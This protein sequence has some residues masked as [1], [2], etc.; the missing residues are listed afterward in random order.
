MVGNKHSPCRVIKRCDE[1]QHGSHNH[2]RSMSGANVDD[3][4]SSGHY[5]TFFTHNP[6]E[7]LTLLDYEQ[8]VNGLFADGHFADRRLVDRHKWDG[9]INNKLYA[10]KPKL[11]E[12]ALAC[13]KSRKEEINKKPCMMKKC[14][15]YLQT[16]LILNYCFLSSKVIIDKW[17]TKIKNKTN[18]PQH[19]SPSDI[20]REFAHR[21]PRKA[22]SNGRKLRPSTGIYGSCKESANKGI[23]SGAAKK[24]A[25]VKRQTVDSPFLAAH[26]SIFSFHVENLLHA[27]MFDVSGLTEKRVQQ[28]KVNEKDKIP[29]IND[30]E[31][32]NEEPNVNA[33]TE[34][35]II[36]LI[37]KIVSPVTI[38]NVLHNAI[39]LHKR[40]VG[41]KQLC[42]LSTRSIYKCLKIEQDIGDV[43]MVHFVDIRF[44]SGMQEG[45]K[46]FQSLH[47]RG[48][49]DSYG[50]NFV[51]LVK[52]LGKGEHWKIL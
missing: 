36:S 9:E 43:Y 13:R 15:H 52:W 18:Q 23:T 45:S 25:A 1:T 27:S 26:K 48:M 10:I 46:A 39:T 7:W 40:V 11:G 32:S 38:L 37:S 19:I 24:W 16:R 50:T 20:I 28:S 33:T 31:V 35:S 21:N 17:L 6:I 44:K 2:L 42:L 5:V 3:M 12:W 29:E 49:K 4:V 51:N 30:A 47:V 14:P 41:N 34:E 22:I 8:N